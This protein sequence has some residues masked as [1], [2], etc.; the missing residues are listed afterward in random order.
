MTSRNTRLSSI[1]FGEPM[2]LKDGSRLQARGC[3]LRDDSFEWD[4]RKAAS[5]LRKHKVSFDAARQVFAEE[6]VIDE[7]D[8]DA[9][10][11]RWRRIGRSGSGI[12]VVTYVERGSRIRII[13]ARKANKHE[14]TRHEN[15]TS[16]G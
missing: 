7:P 11:D 15:Q 13:S 16:T 6:H 14:K 5:N 2:P 3:G 4:D 9:D 10:E 8:P 1:A 12:L